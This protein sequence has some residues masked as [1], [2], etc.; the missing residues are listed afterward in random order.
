MSISQ[1]EREIVRVATASHDPRVRMGLDTDELAKLDTRLSSLATR[2]R[3]ADVPLAHTVRGAASSAFR[4]GGYVDDGKKWTY[5]SL[6]IEDLGATAD[7]GAA[8]YDVGI[9]LESLHVDAAL[10]PHFS[11]LMH[12]C[13]D[14]YDAVNPIGINADVVAWYRVAELIENA[15]SSTRTTQNALKQ[16]AQG[17]DE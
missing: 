2:F 6:S 11:S 14:E 5:S 3:A 7:E 8:A 15:T 1:K 13:L 9:Y 17:Q 4:Y 10:Q 16:W 12:A